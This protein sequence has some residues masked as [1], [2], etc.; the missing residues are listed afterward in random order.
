MAVQTFE[1][2]AKNSGDT[3][4][5]KPGGN[6]TNDSEIAREMLP[7]LQKHLTEAE[8]IDRTIGSSSK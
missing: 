2:E 8:Q 4:R 5:Q 7:T 6:T 1:R 3:T